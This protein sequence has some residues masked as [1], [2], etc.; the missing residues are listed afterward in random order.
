MITI[1]PWLSVG[2]ANAAVAFYQRAFAATVGE[3]V[4]VDGVVQ[5]AELIAQDA[6]FW[7][8]HD[9]ELPHDVD[10][11]RAVRMIIY[12]D[13][14][15]AAYARALAAGATEVAAVH[16][17]NGW[18]TGRFVDPFGHQWETARRTG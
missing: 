12:V 9:D 1:A 11:G 6:P 8:Q 14:P 13:D 2:D 3:L 15:D 4:D 7:V 5:V 10:P 18:R 17:E 16:E